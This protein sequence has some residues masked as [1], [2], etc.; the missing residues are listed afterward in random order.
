MASIAGSGVQPEHAVGDRADHQGRGDE[1][2]R[3]A[4]GRGS[5]LRRAVA[6]A[7]RPQPLQAEP[8]GQE[9]QPEQVGHQAGIDEQ[10]RGA[11]NSAALEP[12]GRAQEVALEPGRQRD[13]ADAAGDRGQ[14]I[15]VHVPWNS[16]AG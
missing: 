14:A 9:D 12:G 13:D 10:Q 7:G 8:D 3:D 16:S 1:R 5:W 11:T 2:E 6:T 15:S 4:A